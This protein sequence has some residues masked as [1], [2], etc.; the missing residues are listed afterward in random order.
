MAAASA[1]ERRTM[2]GRMVLEKRNSCSVLLGNK[3]LIESKQVNGTNK[4]RAERK[5]ADD[6]TLLVLCMD[7]DD[8]LNLPTL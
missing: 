5:E 7:Q 8:H 1:A 2:A 3:Q 6:A 4:E